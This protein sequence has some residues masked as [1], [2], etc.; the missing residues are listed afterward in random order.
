MLFD[1]VFKKPGQ[2]NPEGC[3]SSFGSA[4]ELI[5]QAKGSLHDRNLSFGLASVKV[6]GGSY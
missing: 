5:I 3:G 6:L 1:G 4:V 2:T